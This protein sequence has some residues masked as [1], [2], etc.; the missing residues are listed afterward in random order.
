MLRLNICNT[1]HLLNLKSSCLKRLSFR[2]RL[3]DGA[4][5]GFIL[6]F[7]L[8]LIVNL[9]LMPYETKFSSKILGCPTTY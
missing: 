1:L 2:Y 9:F 7:F 6:R 8:V 4:Q 5:Y 3:E